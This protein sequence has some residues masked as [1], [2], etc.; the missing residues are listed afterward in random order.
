MT[1]HHEQPYIPLFAAARDVWAANQPTAA[2]LAAELRAAGFSRLEVSEMTL[3]YRMALDEWC[4]IVTRR[5]WSTFSH[6]T[7]GEL[8]AGVDEIRAAAAGS[9]LLDIGDRL[10]LLSASP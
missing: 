2:Q 6:F 5:F 3:T 4:S 8:K 10:M 7:D 1:R 9:Q